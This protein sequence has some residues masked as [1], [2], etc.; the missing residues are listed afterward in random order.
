MLY[1]VITIVELDGKRMD[2]FSDE[3]FIAKGEKIEITGKKSSSV[4]VRKARA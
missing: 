3:G 1:E 2:A 4:V